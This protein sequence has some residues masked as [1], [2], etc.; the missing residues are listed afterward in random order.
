[1][2]VFGYVGVYVAV[3]VRDRVLV[4]EKSV[5]ETEEVLVK[6]FVEDFEN[7]SV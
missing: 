5:A 3:I 1:M 6:D 4:L 7:V 2:G